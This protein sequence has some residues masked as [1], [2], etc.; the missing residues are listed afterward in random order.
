M[1]ERHINDGCEALDDAVADKD[2][3][4]LTPRNRVEVN[5]ACHENVKNY[6]GCNED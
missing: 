5:L 4:K 2:L 6:G 3:I 1:K